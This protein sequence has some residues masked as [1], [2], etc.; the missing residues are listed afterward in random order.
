MSE[1][2][3]KPTGD[4]HYS[5]DDLRKEAKQ[6]LQELKK[7]FEQMDGIGVSLAALADKL[8]RPVLWVTRVRKRFGLPVL[9]YYPECYVAFL[10]KIRDLRNLGVSEEKLS[11]LWDLER[12]LIEILHLDLGGGDLS[13]IEGCSV[14]VDPDRRLLLSNAD[15]GVPLMA[16]DVQAGLDFSAGRPKELFEGKEMGEDALRLLGEYRDLLQ[17]VREI[18]GRERKVLWDSLQ[19]TKTAGLPPRHL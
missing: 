6:A 9:E 18:V 12:K 4:D 14:E 7:C 16:R 17:E 10:R 8:G 13:L 19:W 15:L 2:K 11:D 3:P 1:E 5:A